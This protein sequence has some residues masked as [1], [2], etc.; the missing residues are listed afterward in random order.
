MIAHALTIVRNELDRHLATFG[1]NSPHAELGNIAE[2]GAGQGGGATRDRIILS[3]VNIQEERALKNVVSHVR[4]EVTLQVRYHQPPISL[5]LAVLVAATHS[6]YVDALTAL[7]R[8]LAFFQFTPVFTPATVAP[9]SLTDGAPPNA[10]DRLDEFRLVF[11]L[12][13][14]SM[15]E[16]NDMWGMLGGKQ[17]PFALFSM[18][19][20][21][22]KFH[23]VTHE[24]RLITDI[25]HD[26]TH[27][28]PRPLVGPHH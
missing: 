10:L 16:V 5:N 11:N 2:T 4:D 28:V 23:A 9:A 12:W 6:R 19:M 8:A 13:S 15:E 17:F 27:E 20:L 7:S 26:Y 3:M 1:G 21:E 24:G 14:P 25:I 22:L 18:R